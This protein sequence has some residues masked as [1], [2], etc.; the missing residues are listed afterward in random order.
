MFTRYHHIFPPSK[1]SCLLGGTTDYDGQVVVTANSRHPGGVNLLTAD[2]SVRFVKDTVN[3][4]VCMA[5][6]TISLSEVIDA[7]GY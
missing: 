5:L 2:G 4:R 3:A 7:E 1:P 6:G